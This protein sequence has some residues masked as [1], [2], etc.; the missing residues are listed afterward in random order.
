[1]DRY[2]FRDLVLGKSSADPDSCITGKDGVEFTITNG[3]GDFV[4]FVPWS[5]I[6]YEVRER[7]YK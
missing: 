1:M 5:N 2:H 4:V 6:K 3:L 7:H